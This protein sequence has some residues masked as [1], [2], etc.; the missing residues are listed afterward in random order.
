MSLDVISL[1][2]TTSFIVD[3]RGKTVPTVDE[4]I[5]LIKTNCITNGQ[6]YP[7]IDGA[8]FVS[9]ETYENWFRAHP[10]PGDLILTLKG[11]QNGAVA[12]VPNPVEF[13]IAQDMVAL[14]INPEV[15]NPH[16]LLAALRS[17]EV[18]HQI[19]TLD[20]SGV[21]PHLKKTDFDKLILP[22]PDRETQDYIGELYYSLSSKIETLREQNQTLEEL[23]QTLFKRWFVEFE[24]PNENGQPYKSSG[25]K[26]VESELGEIPEGWR[27]GTLGEIIINHDS[28]RIP[29]SSNQRVKRQGIY[30]YHGATSIMDYVD[31]YIFDGRFLLLGEDGTVVDDK[32]YPI[33]QFVDGKIWVNN[34]A[35]V[36]EGKNP[37]TTNYI[38]LLLK[39]TRVS[40]IV[41]GAVQLKINQ[42]NLNSL[43]VL[44]PK[45][46]IVES[47]EL[48]T[49]AL[50]NKMFSN[51]KEIQSL[52]QLRDTLLPKLM[53][54]ELKIKANE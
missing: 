41:T 4:G 32:G 28:K 19:K 24:F 49:E 33:L 36:L 11:S 2:D 7:R 29:L 35:H 21:I 40:Q 54:G 25:G 39:R 5:P 17:R 48:N 42:G 47:F 26:M 46:D 10:L 27:V 53:S 22:Y 8:F 15:I 13:V 37:F 18:Q 31:D 43:E 6:L 50:I 12:L 1:A 51:N 9:N 52:T 23:A 3:N 30:P 16:Y 38:F 45:R 34:H 14:R 20:V 44:I